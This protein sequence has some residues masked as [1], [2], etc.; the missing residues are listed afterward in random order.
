MTQPP[1]DPQIEAEFRDAMREVY[2]RAKVELDYNAT[3]FLQMLSELGPLATARK[4]VMANQPSQGFTVLW[5]KNRL[6]L[7]VEAQVLRPEFAELFT[8]DELETARER[9]AQYGYA[10]P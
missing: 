8:D 6:D 7:S 9:L 5:E 10:V 4:L 2:R 1:T 3:Y